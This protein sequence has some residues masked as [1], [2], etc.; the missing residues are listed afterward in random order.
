[1]FTWI[2]AG[3]AGALAIGGA[4]MGASAQ[5]KFSEL[6]DRCAPAC[7]DEE[8]DSVATRVTGANVMFGLAGAA[9]VTAVILFFVEGRS[10]SGKQE[11]TSSAL[12][13]KVRPVLGSGVMGLGADV[14]F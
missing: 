4:L 2:L 10:A 9:A 5:S 11:S 1:M 8:V 7:S 13:L 14:R 12:R 6:E 3:T